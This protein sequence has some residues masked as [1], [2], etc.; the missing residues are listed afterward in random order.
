MAY[1]TINKASTYYFQ[2]QFEGNNTNAHAITG[3]G[4]QPDLVIFKN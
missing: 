2:K 4:F 1:T 3:V